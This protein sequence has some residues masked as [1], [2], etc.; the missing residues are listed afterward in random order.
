MRYPR[1]FIDN[2]EDFSQISGDEFNHLKNVLR[3][4]AGDIIEVCGGSGLVRQCVITSIGKNCAEF[5]V[6]SEYISS[7]EEDYSVTLYQA[8]PK[9]DKLELIAK[10]FT[11][12]G[13]AA[14]VPFVSKFSQVRKESV[15]VD[16]LYKISCEAAKQCGRAVPLDISA[17]VEFNAMLELLCG[18]DINIFA[19]ERAGKDTLKSVL[20]ASLNGEKLGGKDVRIGIIIGCEGGFDEAEAQA[21]QRAGAHTITLGRRILRL[22]TASVNLMSKINSFFE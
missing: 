20:S 10:M 4:K 12:L 9:S 2:A 19:Y 22:E 13:G 21:I 6:Q 15:R 14:V 7:A 18:N 16:R 3:L 1:F 11:E 8:L 5:S 17:P